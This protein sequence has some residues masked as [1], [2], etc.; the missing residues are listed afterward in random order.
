MTHQTQHDPA[1][2][3]PYPPHADLQ[4][5]LGWCQC[6][7]G[8]TPHDVYGDVCNDCAGVEFDV[9][10]MARDYEGRGNA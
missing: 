7:A 2:Y 8:L 6:G 3:P 1:N 9:D 4:A 5:E 10:S